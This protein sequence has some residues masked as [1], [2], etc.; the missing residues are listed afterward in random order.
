MDPPA[1]GTTMSQTVDR[2]KPTPV[3]PTQR[4]DIVDALRGLAL[5]GVL[6]MNLVT[7]FRVSLFQQFQPWTTDQGFN[8]AVDGLLDIFFD[9][10]A[11]AVF[12]LLFGIGLA[13]QYERLADNPRRLIFLVRRLLALLTFGLIHLFLI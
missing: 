12:S 1:R 6:T 3:P 11:F 9:L 4:I 7:A 13:I 2:T 10:K 5:F 8:R